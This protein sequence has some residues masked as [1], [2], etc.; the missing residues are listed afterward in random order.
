M[1]TYQQSN[2]EQQLKELCKKY[3]AAK[4][5]TLWEIRSSQKSCD[6]QIGGGNL[7]KLLS[8]SA[9]ISYKIQIKLLDFFGKRWE[10][11]ILSK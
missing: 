3:L 4:E 8:G 7:R 6:L 1:T 11:K 9:D 2:T 10:I 5:I